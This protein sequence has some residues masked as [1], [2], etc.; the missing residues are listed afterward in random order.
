MTS[1]PA[2]TE[3][4]RTRAV[5]LG[6]S[7]WHT[8]LYRDAVLRRH[9]V[10]AVQDARPD[11]VDDG[12]AWGAPIVGSIDEALAFPDVEV[13]Y[14]LSPHD[15]VASTCRALVGRGIPFAVEK[16]LGV[17]L[18]ELRSVAAAA[19]AAAVPATVALVQRGGPVDAWLRKAGRIS[20]ERASFVAGP[21]SRYRRGGSPWMLD[22]ARAGGGALV[23]LGPHF[24]DL[25]LQHLGSAAVSL[26][27]RS[28]ALHGE[29][30]EDHATLV[31]TT[32]DG[33]EA[34][35]EVGYA[36]PD[37]PSK[38]YCSFTAAGT[39]GFVSIDTDGTAR[40]TGTDGASEQ[41]VIDVD[42]D[43]LYTRF[44]DAVADSLADGFR[45]MPTLDDL[46]ETMARI[47]DADGSEESER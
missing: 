2:S 6:G 25:A 11:S 35:I 19:R 16:P 14:V 42:S 44:V 20:Y 7:H 31:L 18:D 12:D 5:V 46:E 22:P 34:V 4:R 3:P 45:G 23:N 33:R 39:D 27:S 21:P 10:L 30:V 15:E 17:D 9:D 41:T 29:A 28:R 32:D 43:P 26:R 24:V 38:R 1:A 8:P 37:A 36:F 40:F 47:W 13:A